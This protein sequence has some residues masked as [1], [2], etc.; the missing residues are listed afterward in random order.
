MTSGA[1]YN[2]VVNYDVQ[3]FGSLVNFFLQQGTIPDVDSDHEDPDY[4]P[5]DCSELDQDF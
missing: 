1:Q 3:W 5:E 4:V 2:Q